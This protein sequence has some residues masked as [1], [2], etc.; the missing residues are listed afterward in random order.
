MLVNVLNKT[1]HKSPSFPG[2][3][4]TVREA[5]AAAKA[6]AKST[7][8]PK[9]SKPKP[10]TR[11]RKT[12][13][14]KGKNNNPFAEPPDH[15]QKSI[16]AFCKLRGSD[17]ID[18][19]TVGEPS[20]SSAVTMECVEAEA[21]SGKPAEIMKTDQD[22][23]PV[24]S[25]ADAEMMNADQADADVELEQSSGLK[26]SECPTV[27]AAATTENMKDVDDAKAKNT[28]SPTGCI[29][30]P[31]TSF[32]Q[33]EDV[34]PPGKNETIG[35]LLRC[36]LPRDSD[37]MGKTIAFFVNLL[38][39]GRNEFRAHLDSLVRQMDETDLEMLEQ[40]C[41]IN[42]DL[43]EY[44]NHM[45]ASKTVDAD[46]SFCGDEPVED[47][48]DFMSWLIE[49]GRPNQEAQPPHTPMAHTILE[50]KARFSKF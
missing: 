28:S 38:L 10:A 16:S 19:G 43:P 40:Q 15:D 18:P 33:V 31:S 26:E 50:M 27:D 8:K 24:G 22:D 13:D 6:K 25:K 39:D 42:P 23:A 37:F 49:S 34:K 3:A 20:L 32:V 4:R 1:F 48:V 46:W 30:S 29:D 17:A 36:F 12:S 14:D 35:V 41:V 47:I 5:K 44:V 2:M 21:H 11:K 45:H 7:P 9:A